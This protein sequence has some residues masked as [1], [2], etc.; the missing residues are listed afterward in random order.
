MN[1]EMDIKGLEEIARASNDGE[2]YMIIAKGDGF[3]IGL[4]ANSIDGN[5]TKFRFEF[6]V[7]FLDRCHPIT[8]ER[9][10]QA[11]RITRTLTDRGYDLNNEDDGWVYAEREVDNE[12]IGEEIAFLEELIKDFDDSTISRSGRFS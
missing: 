7:R 2:G 5:G 3:R 4:V 6:L 12:R 9:M 11:A 8:A 1:E 10:E